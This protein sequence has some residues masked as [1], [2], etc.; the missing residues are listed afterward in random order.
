MTFWWHRSWL[1]SRR[2]AKH[3]CAITLAQMAFIGGAKSS[4]Q[5]TTNNING[6]KSQRAAVSFKLHAVFYMMR[7]RFASF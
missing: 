5:R 3:I 4:R 7:Q 2:R 6:F 1:S